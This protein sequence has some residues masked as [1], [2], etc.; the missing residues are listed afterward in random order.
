MKRR[1]R[2]GWGVLEKAQTQ[3][4]WQLCG[5]FLR[6]R[7]RGQ[8]VSD[9]LGPRLPATLKNPVALYERNLLFPFRHAWRQKS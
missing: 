1:V 9:K 4:S 3:V 6:Q 7:A 5:R 8:R 2:K